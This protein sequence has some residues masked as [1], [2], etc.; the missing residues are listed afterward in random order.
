MTNCFRFICSLLA[1]RQNPHHAP[2]NTPLS[3]V[4]ATATHT[5]SGQCDTSQESHLFHLSPQLV[6][7]PTSQH[8]HLRE[9][10]ATS[11]HPGENKNAK[12]ASLYQNFCQNALP[13]TKPHAHFSRKA[14]LSPYFIVHTLR[15]YTVHTHRHAPH[16]E[17]MM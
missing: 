2:H 15:P 1:N 5:D 6:N 14:Y 7:Y 4:Q 9:L 17:F 13:P 3:T 10:T 16:L 11:R 8:R 12:H